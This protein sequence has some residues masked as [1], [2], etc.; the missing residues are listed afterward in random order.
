MILHALFL[1][2]LALFLAFL[3]LLLSS[4][5]QVK[6]S[7]PQQQPQ[8][9]QQLD[10]VP[11]EAERVPTHAHYSN[12]FNDV[13]GNETSGIIGEGQQE[14]FIP[15][16][17]YMSRYLPTEFDGPYWPKGSIEPDFIFPGSDPKRPLRSQNLY[18][19][20]PINP[21]S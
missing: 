6:Q 2:T 12:K 13:I 11:T 5:K 19:S 1:L 15:S 3:Y 7:Q 10:F 20:Q 16:D 8:P 17:W 18:A 4:Q 14:V 21:L 9:L